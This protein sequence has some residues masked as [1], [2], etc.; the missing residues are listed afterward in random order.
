MDAIYA[1]T[2]LQTI[3]EENGW[4]VYG[5]MKFMGYYFNKEEA[6]EDVEINNCNINE[7]LF[8]YAVIEEIEPGLYSFPRRRWFFEFDDDS[9][10]YHLI[11]EPKIMKHI[12]NVL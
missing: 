7:C 5:A 11:E 2:C 6:I 10:T 4:P 8:R 12:A 1:I 9:E 3:E